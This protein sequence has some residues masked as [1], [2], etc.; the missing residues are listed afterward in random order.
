[1][2]FVNSGCPG[3]SHHGHDG[4]KGTDFKFVVAVVGLV[5]TIWQ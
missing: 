3:A 5:R 4:R 1:V 2:T